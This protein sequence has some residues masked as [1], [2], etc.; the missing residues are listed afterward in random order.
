MYLS[1][2]V[3]MT[4][5]S[6]KK[7]KVMKK[8]NDISRKWLIVCFV[9]SLSILFSSSG[10]YRDDALLFCIKP[11]FQQLT[12]QKT[13]DGIT[14]DLD[15]LDNYLNSIQIKQL[16]PWLPGAAS[17]DH[18]GDVYLN[19][20]YRLT[21]GENERQSIALIRNQ[22]DG[23]SVIHSAEL[24]PI[25]KI[26]Y[27]PNDPQY[28]QQWFLSQINADEAWNFWDIDGGEIPG[29]ESVILASVDLGVNWR[30]PDLVDNIWQNLGEDAD[31][32]G[33]TI[34][35]SGGQ[36][37]YDPGD[38]NGFDDDNWDNNLSTHIDDLIG[39]DV[40][41]TSYGD[42]DPDPPH[43]GGWSHGTHVAGLLSSTTDNNTGV[44]STAFSCSIMSVK[45]TGDDEN[46]QYITNSQ[47][48]ILYAAK[49]GYYA[50]GFSIVNCS[51]GGGGY[52]S[53]EQDVM[54]ILRN[55]YNALIFASAGNG[56]GGEDD[57][58]QY[59][60]S[61]ENVISVT[62]LGQNDSWNHW[63]T[64]N[65]FVDLASP[66]E[67][68]RSTTINGYSSWT[69]TS[70]A[71][72]V[73]ASC[74]GLLKSLYPDWNSNQV[75]TMLLATADPII[76]SINSESYLQGQL[77]RG[78]VDILKAVEVALF[79]QIE[80]VDVDIA[81]L[82][83]SDN[84]INPGESIELRAILYANEIWG[85]A[86]DV[87]GTLSAESNQVDISSDMAYFG[88]MAPGEV[89]LN[90]TDPFIIQ[91]GNNIPGGIV[92]FNLSLISNVEAE[93]EYTTD[94]SFTIYV[95]DGSGEIQLPVDHQDGWNL[96]G[97]PLEVENP[98]YLILFPDAIEGT[99][100][101]FQ[102]S[103]EPEIDLN[104]GEGYWLRFPEQGSNQLSGAQI[105][106][107]TIQLNENWNL[108]SGITFTTTVYSIV[109]PNGLII[110]GTFYGYNGGYESTETLEPGKGYWVRSIAQGSV[111]IV[112]DFAENSHNRSKL[113]NTFSDR[114]KT[115]HSIRFNGQ[116][117]YFGL[118]LPEAERLSYSLPP[119]PPAG[120]KDIR[121][122]GNTKLCATDECVIEVMNNENLLTLE[123]D[124][125][126]GER[127]EL[128]PVIAGEMKWSEAISLFGEEQITFNSEVE[129]WIMR[130]FAS[131]FPESFAL[132]PAYP[133]P[134][135]P[136]TTIRFEIPFV[137]THSNASLRIYDITGRLVETL[138]DEILEPGN[139]T[140]QW[141]ANTFSSGVYFVR[142]EAGTFS[143]SQK[144]I[145][146]K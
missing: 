57:T 87:I 109:D 20:I 24:D 34:I 56:D 79:P 124:I 138:G 119:K 17:E 136:I 28:N 146:L 10:H 64:Y 111:T 132:H 13:P 92:E 113:I 73:A 83:G 48:G 88:S 69:G 117:L 12:I 99:L 55:D 121:F 60:A 78:R 90:E 14:V 11:E 4:G 143:Q 16:E 44:A 139:Q 95:D 91:F 3:L 125:I 45:C 89:S 133:N 126:N 53:Y 51:F 26:S 116:T 81:V 9:C 33:Q 105:N 59:P 36:W 71:S 115:A 27:T 106:S 29:D 129:Q 107:V 25:R 130:K 22:I 8:R 5:H 134:F 43:S 145:L 120:A 137:Q 118:N 2:E 144:L 93:I 142:L 72:P 77:G 75:E 38:L 40:S 58:P 65:E 7:S 74:A 102:E 49:A 94:L 46:P 37:I 101:S 80:F 66:G 39:W 35:Y 141:N 52:S 54:D 50:Q 67:N 21:L 63:A 135:N 61:Y 23:L 108:I 42:N 112:G 128:I 85:T 98:N 110:S 104:H 70:M 131:T 97:L 62:A 84:D 19:R 18:R 114:M 103:Y 140:I 100:Y 123:F 47:A 32:D 82:D 76:Y 31:G 6:I 122:S 41:E 15:L 30:H 96:V 1:R 68:I 127:W 86:V